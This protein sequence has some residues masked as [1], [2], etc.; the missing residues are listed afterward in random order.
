V[1][2]GMT[3]CSLEDLELEKTKKG[4]VVLDEMLGASLGVEAIHE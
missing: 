4:N 2:R 1:A 3:R